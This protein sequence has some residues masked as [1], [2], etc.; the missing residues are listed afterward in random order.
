[1]VAPAP[2]LGGCIRPTPRS[3]N[4]PEPKISCVGGHT[5]DPLG[6]KTRC[7]GEHFEKYSG[8]C[9]HGEIGAKDLTLGQ[10]EGTYTKSKNQKTGQNGPS[11]VML[12]GEAHGQLVF[13]VPF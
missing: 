3:L 11:L 2:G 9:C 10:F 6:A 12:A 4:N 5:W 1:M 7:F 8:V 13:F